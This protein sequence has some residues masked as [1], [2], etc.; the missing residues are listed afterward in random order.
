MEGQKQQALFILLSNSKKEKTIPDTPLHFGVAFLCSRLLHQMTYGDAAKGSF[1]E[2]SYI[3]FLWHILRLSIQNNND[4][5]L[6]RALEYFVHVARRQGWFEKYAMS[7]YEVVSSEN[8]GSMALLDRK[9]EKRI[10][11]LK[12]TYFP[13]YVKAFMLPRIVDAGTLE[14]EILDHR[15]FML[16][17][18]YT[19][20]SEDFILNFLY[21][22]EC[23]K[24]TTGLRSS[25][26]FSKLM[27]RYP[28][29]HHNPQVRAFIKKSIRLAILNPMAL[30]IDQLFQA[31]KVY[32]FVEIS[33]E[34]KILS[35]KQ[36]EMLFNCILAFD[37]GVLRGKISLL[38]RFRWTLFNELPKTSF[39][40]FEALFKEY[41][42]SRNTRAQ[43]EA[44]NH[45]YERKFAEALREQLIDSER[46]N[47][48]ENYVCPY[49]GKEIDIAYVSGETML[50][51]HL[52]GYQYHYYANKV[53]P[54]CETLV[55][56]RAHENAGWKNSVFILLPIRDMHGNLILDQKT[57]DD[58][59]DN[60]KCIIP[61]LLLKQ[62]QGKLLV[63]SVAKYA[64]RCFSIDIERLRTIHERL[65]E[66]NKYFY[67]Y[68]LKR[69]GIL[70]KD[71]SLRLRDNI[72]S[73]KADSIQDTSSVSMT[74]VRPITNGV[75][76]ASQ[77]KTMLTSYGSLSN[78]IKKLSKKQDQ[79][80]SGKHSIRSVQ[81]K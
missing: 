76:D 3:A 8:I 28:V 6:K 65:E 59:I 61:P 53:E 2:V 58:F 52:D 79:N 60:A 26:Y 25:D 7:E 36:R 38:M 17:S 75:F 62:N 68:W 72:K 18:H 30:T 10:G 56:N 50:A 67:D 24:K 9:V 12:S 22:V 47:L 5:D 71:P 31:F 40:I 43:M 80:R 51:F 74:N 54:D 42:E 45:P 57:K 23:P 66:I 14:Q 34:K 20:F 4:S 13:Q 21:A 48:K 49:T 19:H 11:F 15:F 35:R 73:A 70:Y 44:D 78:T 81:M 27:L 77:S 16:L 69:D 1:I 63:V 32:E 46:S 39:S 29:N 55:R 41:Y 64:P 33:L 37:G